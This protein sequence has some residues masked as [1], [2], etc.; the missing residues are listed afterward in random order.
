MTF[1][2]M[3]FELIG[4]NKEI[5]ADLENYVHLIEETNK[6]LNLTGF[7]GD[8]LWGEG[9]YQ[10]IILMSASFNDTKNKKMLDI[11]AGAGFPSVPFLIYKRNFEL[12]ICEPNQKRTNFL[13]MVNEK[14][15]LNM[16]FIIG[17]IEDYKE[18]ELFDL[19]TAR[20][21]T[22]LK[23]LIEISSRVGAIHAEYSFL[24]GP[25][26]YEELKEADWIIN[27]LLLK[28]E[29][30]KVKVGENVGDFKTHYLCKYKKE[31]PTP[32]KYPRPWLL[33]NQK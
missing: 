29:I 23:N 17:R 14:L 20:A 2:E 11:G 32:S 22:S 7:T 16:K 18:V 4:R 6:F 25:K 26:I 3:T 15:S 19:I 33:V 5:F 27:E 30:F 13:K 21:V 8:S 1:K 9:V 31:R 28:I 10:S 24:K 12:Y